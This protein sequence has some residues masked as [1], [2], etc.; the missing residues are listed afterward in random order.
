FNTISL[1]DYKLIKKPVKLNK[2]PLAELA[3]IKNSNE[4]SHYKN[5][6]KKLANA[7]Y[8]FKNQIKEGLSEFELKQIFE[9]SLIK[10]GAFCTSFKTI[11]A[12]GENSS[13]IHYSACSKEKILKEG[14]IILLDCGGYYEGGYATDITR[15]FLCGTKAGEYVKKIYTAVLKAQLNTMNSNLKK[16]DALH[17]LAAKLLKEYEK[18]GFFFPHGLGHGIG[19]PVH[20]SPPVLSSKSRMN[21]KNGNVFSI[22]PGLYKKGSFGIRIE[23]AVYLENGKKIALSLFPYEEKLINRNLLTKKELTMLDN[24]NELTRGV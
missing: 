22:E 15:V 5:S 24:W 1:F 13:I 21:I 6:Y 9:N 17:N 2:N 16:T 11:L 7:L 14:D 3:A 18:E 10:N 19:I 20:Q 4:I 23:N 8:D 12:I